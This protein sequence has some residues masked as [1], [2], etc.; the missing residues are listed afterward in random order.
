MRKEQS[1]DPTN[2]VILHLEPTTTTL[3]LCWYTN[4]A[5]EQEVQLAKQ[6]ANPLEVAIREIVEVEQASDPPVVQPKMIMDLSGQMTRLADKLKSLR[7][8]KKLKK[9]ASSIPGEGKQVHICPK[10]GREYKYQSFLHVHLK[11][12]CTSWRK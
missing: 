11:R 12:K 6:T 5:N 1:N 3:D 7:E 8:T 10:C 4:A 9:V 2:D